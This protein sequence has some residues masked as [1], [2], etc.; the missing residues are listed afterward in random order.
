[1]SNENKTIE[2]HKKMKLRKYI[3]NHLCYEEA[4]IKELESGKDNNVYETMENKNWKCI[5]VCW[6]CSV[7]Q[8]DKGSKPKACLAARAL[9]EIV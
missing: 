4:K 9:R 3:N 8:I 5:S 1:M 7:K 2:E 6:V